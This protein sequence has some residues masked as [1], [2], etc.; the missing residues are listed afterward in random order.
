MKPLFTLNSILVILMIL[1]S[2]ANR[3]DEKQGKLIRLNLASEY[4]DQRHVDVWLPPCYDHNPKKSYPVLYMHDGQNLFVSETSYGGESWEVGETLERLIAEKKIKACIVVGIWNT[5]KR[6][7]EY[8]PQ[9][10]YPSL[11][12]ETRQALQTEFNFPDGPLSDAYLYYIVSELK[13]KIDSAFRTLPDRENTF[14]AGSSM[15]GLISMYAAT[16]YPQI[17]GG[18]ACISTH[19]PFR[20]RENS[21]E[22]TYACVKYL[23]PLLPDLKNTRFYFDYG[24]ENL[25][26]WYEPNQKIID[27]LFYAKGFD[28]GNYTSRK[29]EGH[30]HNEKSWRERFEQPAMF[31]FGL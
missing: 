17:F 23:E 15:G 24:T 4:V 19:W 8:A 14:I 27:S 12:E 16:E 21:Q 6:F 1:S 3:C 7:A 5:P 20:I 9:K 22:F 11:R 13:P 29:F 2:C 28:A 25:D 30:D 10:P 31:L 18:A 26:A